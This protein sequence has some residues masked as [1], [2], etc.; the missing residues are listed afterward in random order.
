MAHLFLSKQSAARCYILLF[1]L[2][3][4]MAGIGEMKNTYN[5]L[6]LKPERKTLG[7]EGRIILKWF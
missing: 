6:V 1:Y 3:G 2:V 4:H 5:I 7:V